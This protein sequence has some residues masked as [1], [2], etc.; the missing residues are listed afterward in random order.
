ML[1]S[2]CAC[3]SVDEEETTDSEAYLQSAPVLGAKIENEENV[4]F[5]ALTKN[6]EY[7]WTLIDENGVETVYNH[8]GA[9]CLDFGDTLCTFTR[10]Q[11]GGSVNLKFTGNV[12]SYK[13]YQAPREEIENDRSKIID[14][15]YLISTSDKTITFPESGEYYY[16]VN[17]NYIE[18]EVPYGFLLSE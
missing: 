15:K 13:I 12:F 8:E 14:D 4:G 18:G 2:L 9:F 10:K 1:F 3:S 6:G 5:Y 11:T 16:V 17:V 7:A